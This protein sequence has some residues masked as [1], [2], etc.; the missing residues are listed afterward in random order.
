MCVWGKGMGK[1]AQRRRTY[2]A[3]PLWLFKAI[4]LFPLV[5]SSLTNM[6]KILGFTFGWVWATCFP[7]CRQSDLDEKYLRD[8][9][10]RERKRERE[11]CFHKKR[12]WGF[13][14]HSMRKQTPALKHYSFHVSQD[15]TH[16]WAK[17]KMTKRFFLKRYM[18]IATKHKNG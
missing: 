11:Q 14:F 12:Q 6:L 4:F 9:R 15:K 5:I 18:Y 7:Y 3:N 8:Q 16:S 2:S 17:N 1:G 13:F 10:I